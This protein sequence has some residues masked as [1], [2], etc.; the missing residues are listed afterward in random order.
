MKKITLLLGLL[1]IGVYNSNAQQLIS[2]E[3][4]EGFSLG[5]INGQNG[6][7][8]N[9]NYTSFVTVVDT[10]STNGTSSLFFSSDPNG[11]VPNNGITGTGIN[12]F[13]FGDITFTADI[14]VESGPSPSEFNI[15]LQ[16]L[17]QNALT[18]RVV[19]FDGSIILVD[20][21]PEPQFVNAGTFT[22]DVWFE[23][24][25]VH[26]FIAGTIEY[27][28]DDTLFYSGSVVNGTG[29]EEMLLFSSFNQTGFYI[30]NINFTPN[31]L[32]SEEFNTISLKAYPNPASEKLFLTSKNN[33]SINSVKV[34]DLSG[35]EHR[36]FLNDDNSIN[37][38]YLSSGM[39]VLRVKTANGIQ[40]LKFIKQ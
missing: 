10:Q 9:P 31:N 28:V 32:S 14:F 19:F 33:V 11:P 13:N 25:I 38:D 24:K 3:A 27:F 6:W 2:F 5:E 1:F 23:F 20:S 26:D 29:I 15:I 21:I 16:S 22:Q 36:V 7:M 8:S 39:Y 37:V 34:F 12:G 30:D 35:R 40:K 17:S 4:S 18:S